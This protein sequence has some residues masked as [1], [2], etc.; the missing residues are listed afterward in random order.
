MNLGYNGQNYF[1]KD[2]YVNEK[3]KEINDCFLANYKSHLENINSTID[4]LTKE[5]DKQTDTKEKKKY[6]TAIA[7]L[8]EIKK[9]FIVRYS[10]VIDLK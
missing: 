1:S 2:E 8:E 10:S 3:L 9:L 5:K 7:K 4:K 6:E